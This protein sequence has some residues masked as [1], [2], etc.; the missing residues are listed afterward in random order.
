MYIYNLNDVKVKE[1]VPGYHGKFVHTENMTLAYWNIAA[2][3][4]LPEHT[5]PHEQVVNVLEGT[6]ELAI[7]GK[8]HELKEGSVMV[9]PGGVPHSGKSVTTCRVIDVFYPV[10]EDYQ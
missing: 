2:G 7:E 9:I 5:H 3:S 10:R 8:V 1:I 6:M 4:P